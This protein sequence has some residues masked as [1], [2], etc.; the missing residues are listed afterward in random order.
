MMFAKI[1]QFFDSPT[2]RFKI[3]KI[4]AILSPYWIGNIRIS[5]NLL[6]HKWSLYEVWSEFQSL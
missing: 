3:V 6:F 4:E 2:P 5:V 1:S